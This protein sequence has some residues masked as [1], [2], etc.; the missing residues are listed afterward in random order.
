M[1]KKHDLLG[2]L[3]AA[4]TG[5]SLLAAM[6]LRAFWPAFILPRF[7]SITL[8][9]L[10][11]IALVLDFYLS[12]E[13]KRVYW[14]IPIYAAL[15]FGVFPWVACVTAPLDALKLGLIGAVIFTAVTCLFDTMMKRLW[16]SDV[17]K[18]A[19]LISAFGLFLATQC[20]MGIF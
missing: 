15:I 7:D 5:I 10:S 19:P 1:S 11:L 6:L 8:I 13:K 4:V 9:A 17:N 12:K 20:L 18:L 3:L 14:L 16:G 2:I